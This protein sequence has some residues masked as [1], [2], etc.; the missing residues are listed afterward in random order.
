ME[1]VKFP[2]WQKLDLRTGKILK[3][4]DIEGADKLY[5]LSVDLGKEFGK[6]TIVAGIKPYY[7][8]EQLKNKSC[9]IFTNLEPR[10]IKGI[11]SQGMLLAAASED[12]SKVFL[13]QP[14]GK[15]EEGSRIR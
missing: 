11:Q 2:D 6:R 15:I 13:L 10:T 9:V 7:K 3:V 4:E 12:E 14:D 5:K 1:N 8:P